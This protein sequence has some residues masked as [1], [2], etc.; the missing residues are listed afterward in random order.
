MVLMSSMQ[1]LGPSQNF[2]WLDILALAGGQRLAFSTLV[3]AGEKKFLG[4]HFLSLSLAVGSW[5][6]ISLENPW[7]HL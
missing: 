2:E 7:P 5:L 1:S 6:N 4:S 3:S